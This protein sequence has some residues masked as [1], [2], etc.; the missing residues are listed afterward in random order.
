[1]AKIMINDYDRL[2]YERELK[3]FLP[4]RILDAHVHVSSERLTR[5]G[6]HNGGSAWT[7]YLCKEMPV[8]KLIEMNREMFPKQDVSALIFG[9]CMTDITETNRFVIESNKNF[10]LPML[11][12]SHYTMKPDELEAAVKA[13][14]FLGLKPY[15]SNCP[16]Y[17]PSGEVRIFDFITKEQLELA[18]KNGWIIM[19]HIPR[20]KRLGDPVNIAQIMEIEQNYPN[21]KLIVAHVGRAYTREDFGNAF[22]VLKNTKNMCFDFT[23]NLFDEAIIEGIKTVGTDRFIYGTDL[24]IAFMR[25]YRIIENGTYYNVVPKGLY[26]DVTGQ[27]HM[28]ESDSDEIT[29]MVYEQLKAFKRAA[30]ALKLSDSDV[31]KIMYSNAKRLIDSVR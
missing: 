17:I 19:L 30:A 12:R 4:D 10:G 1:M 9:E 31:E 11:Y 5:N 24:P 15:L 18:D 23:A 13:G 25:M 28:K 16:P 8:E 3:D 14:G 22:E 20:A 29:I 21:L 7:D 26:G 27:P 6:T 2:V